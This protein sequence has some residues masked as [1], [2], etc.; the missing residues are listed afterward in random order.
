MRF[1]REKT[2]TNWNQSQYKGY[3]LQSHIFW[4]SYT[5]CTIHLQ[6]S[7]IQNPVESLHTI[8]FPEF[9]ENGEF[10][11]INRGLMSNASD[12]PVNNR[13]WIPGWTTFCFGKPDSQ[14][15]STIPI[16]NHLHQLWHNGSY[17]LGFHLICGWYLPYRCKKQNKPRNLSKN[18]LSNNRSPDDP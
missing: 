1:L 5:G 12:N 18:K 10:Y 16:R 11:L 3:R 8:P 4:L 6:Y 17:V 2:A 15:I 9:L 7:R 14:E 13:S